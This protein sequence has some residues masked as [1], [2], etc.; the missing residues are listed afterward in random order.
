MTCQFLL[1]SFLPG[2]MSFWD[3]LILNKLLPIQVWEACLHQSEEGNNGEK[4]FKYG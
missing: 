3:W 4:N 1:L 2:L